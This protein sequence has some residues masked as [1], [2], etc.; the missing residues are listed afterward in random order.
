MKIERCGLASQPNTGQRATSLL[1]MNSTGRRG[2]DADIEP[3]HVVGQNQH[4]GFP[5]ALPDLANSHA[6]QG[7]E[8]AVIEPGYLP[9]QPQAKGDTGQ[10]KR[11]QHDGEGH[12]RDDSEDQADHP[13]RY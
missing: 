12:D 6:G 5:A 10:L 1:A 11:Q 9:L 8:G 3:R 2:D 7:I 4:R 13:V